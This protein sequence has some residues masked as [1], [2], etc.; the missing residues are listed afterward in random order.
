M[1][2]WTVN[3]T[4]MDRIVPCLNCGMAVV[5]RPNYDSSKPPGWL[6]IGNVEQRQGD[7]DDIRGVLDCPTRT[8][9]PKGAA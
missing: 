2:D 5:R 1:T 8:A 9:A 4:P 6:H 3:Y 7:Y